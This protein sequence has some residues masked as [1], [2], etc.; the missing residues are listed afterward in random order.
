MSSIQSSPLQVLEEPLYATSL[1]CKD[2]ASHWNAL[3]SSSSNGGNLMARRLCSLGLLNEDDYEDAQ[4]KRACTSNVQKCCKCHCIFGFF[5]NDFDLFFDLLSCSKAKTVHSV[6]L[7]L[8]EKEMAPLHP[9]IHLPTIVCTILS[10]Q[11]H[12]LCSNENSVDH[13]YV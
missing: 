5:L 4:V 10:P 8:V 9:S 1:I 7:R 3:D 13:V 6:A 2:A 11:V 12:A